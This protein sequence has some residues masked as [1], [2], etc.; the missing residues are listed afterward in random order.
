M[1]SASR[2][3]VVLSM[4]KGVRRLISAQ[5]L[6]SSRNHPASSVL[7]QGWVLILQP[8]NGGSPLGMPARL[9][10]NIIPAE[11]ITA[12]EANLTLSTRLGYLR[13]YGEIGALVPRALNL[14][15]PRVGGECANGSQTSFWA[16]QG[17]LLRR[18]IHVHGCRLLACSNV[19]ACL[20]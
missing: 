7:A 15:T 20:F 4:L 17:C 6:W 1:L 10:K 18:S 12:W 2:S 11:D 5:N 19:S 16:V 13:A 14:G 3:F 9:D 8:G